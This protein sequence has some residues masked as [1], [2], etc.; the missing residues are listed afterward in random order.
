MEL[1]VESL[2]GAAHGERSANRANQRNGYRERTWDTRVGSVGLAIPKLRKGSYFPAFL[3]PRRTARKALTA[4]IQEAYVHGVSTRAVDDLVKAMGMSSISKSQVSR[5]C[6]EVD[7]RVHTLSGRPIEGNWAYLSIDAPYVNVRQAGRIVSV[8][9]IIAVGVNG[10]GRREVLGMQ[11]GASEAEP[12][13]IGFLRS[14]TRRGLRGVKL[15]NSNSHGGLK[16]AA[17]KVLSSTSQRCCV[18]FMRNA[19]APVGVKHRAMV[20]AANRT[21]FTQETQAAAR[22]DWHAVAE[23]LRERFQKL[24]AVMDTAENNVLAHMAFPKEHWTQL[25]S[26]ACDI[27]TNSMICAPLIGNQF[28]TRQPVRPVSFRVGR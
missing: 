8:V 3:E 25:L 20:A 6:A 1:E 5:L 13:W 17:A 14:L 19:L 28:A 21:A 9:T 26:S 12:F 10:D 16:K 27:R 11:V 18:H 22:R 7:E 23:C 4:V 24:A 2:T 15:V